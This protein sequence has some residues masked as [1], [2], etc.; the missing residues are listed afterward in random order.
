[1]LQLRVSGTGAST[2]S[3]IALHILYWMHHTHWIHHAHEWIHFR[4]TAV[5]HVPRNLHLQLYV[6]GRLFRGHHITLAHATAPAIELGH[7]SALSVL[8]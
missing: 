2:Q 3:S 1:V 4:M 6:R 7:L 8:A 5:I